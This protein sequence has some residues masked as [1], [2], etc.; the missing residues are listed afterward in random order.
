MSHKTD[1]MYSKK[2]ALMEHY[3]ST[4]HIGNKYEH[5]KSLS[6]EEQQ[7]FVKSQS[8]LDIISSRKLEDE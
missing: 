5:E 6:S 1:F 8:V 3:K 4:K 2:S 7:A